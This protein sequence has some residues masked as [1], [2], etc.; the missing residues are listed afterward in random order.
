M[1]ARKGSMRVNNVV[2]NPMLTNMIEPC[3][4]DAFM[5]TTSEALVSF[6]RISNMETTIMPRVQSSR[7]NTTL[8]VVMSD[9]EDEAE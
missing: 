8:P 1:I 5:E 2:F 9:G 7:G 6:C 3:A 4:N